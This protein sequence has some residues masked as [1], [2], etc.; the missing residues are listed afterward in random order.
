MATAGTKGVPRPERE[1][2]ILDVA[3][4]HI[5]RV[6][7]AGLS[8]AEV[9]SQAGV[10][11]PLVYG[12]FGTKDGLYA[13]C[14]ERAAAVLADAIENAIASTASLEMAQ[15]TL[16]AIFAALEPRPHDWNVLFDR[17]AP[18]EGP[19]G[20]TVRIARRRIASQAARGIATVFDATGIT[21]PN[22]LSALT[23]V[24]MGAVTSLVNWWLRHPEQTAADMSAR[25]KRLIDALATGQR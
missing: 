23:D 5:G 10:S 7:Y 17:S 14:V 2:Q 1:R 15:H 13:A 25:S 4:D 24:W 22:D 11:K 18:R 8:L 16:D 3:A 6:G 12:Y 19:A 20:D 21:D 9:A